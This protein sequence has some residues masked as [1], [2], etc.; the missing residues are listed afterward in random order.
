MCDTLVATPEVTRDRRML[1]AKNSDRE[2]G[3]AQAVEI[4]AARTEAV[5]R[6]TAID[7]P[8]PSRTR[9]VLLCR[10]YWMW[11][12]EMGVN[13]A[14]VAIGNEAVFT[15]APHADAGLTGMDLVRLG[16]ERA[17]SAPAAVR[18][19][20][21]LLET[22]GQG[23]NAGHRAS[24]RYHNSFLIADGSE[25][26]VL[27][28]AARA[29]VAKQV[30]GVRAISN[31][32]TL[33][34]D[35]DLSSEGLRARAR[36][37]GL[38]PGRDRLDFSGTFGDPLITAAAAAARRRSCTERFLDR[39]RGRIS[40]LTAISALRQHGSP[41]RP[42]RALSGL[43]QTVCAHAGPLPTRAHGQTTGSLV[44]ELNG[45]DS[46]CFVTA[47]AAP[48]LSL[49]K[50]VKVGGELP[51]IGAPTGRY[52]PRALWWRHERLHRLALVDLDAALGLIAAERDDFE[53]SFG[54][55]HAPEAFAQ[56]D[57]L[58]ARWEAALR[59][60]FRRAR[61]SR[62]WRRLDEASGLDAFLAD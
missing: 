27:E 60:R 16:L 20:G 50:P 17:T 52:D 19:I 55:T 3:E 7:V 46:A 26:W 61:L 53:R 13:D 5:T 21:E 4:V 14:G 58:E 40:A 30:H 1:F 8:A 51:E 18:V 12:A 25:A 41:D 32:L 35:W 11:G 29:W 10:P 59:A 28:T 36:D 42:R 22:H 15:R 39:S 31:G 47:T 23:G 45:A 2:P 38:R 6:C 43:F 9:R 34:D 57:E 48:C 37:Y 49:F 44:A 56:A 33:R 24:F 62:Y 54:R